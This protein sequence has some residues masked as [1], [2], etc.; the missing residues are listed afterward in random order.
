MIASLLESENAPRGAICVYPK[1]EQSMNVISRTVDIITH[2]RQSAND[3]ITVPLPLKA[4][5]DCLSGIGRTVYS[6]LTLRIIEY[7]LLVLAFHH[8]PKTAAYGFIAGIVFSDEVNNT[9]KNVKSIVKR[10]PWYASIFCA[11]IGGAS[12]YS[13][14]TVSISTIGFCLASNRGLRLI[15]IFPPKD[16]SKNHI[17]KIQDIVAHLYQ[18]ANNNIAVPLKDSSNNPFAEGKITC[19]LSLKNIVA[20]AINIVVVA[21]NIVVVASEALIEFGLTIVTF[22]FLPEISF[23]GFAAA[24]VFPEKIRETVN[25]INA[26]YT[27]LKNE[28]IYMHIL[29]LPFH[30][31]FV[32]ASIIA[33]PVCVPV[34]AFY[35]GSKLVL[36]I[37]EYLV[38][39]KKSELI[40]VRKVDLEQWLQKGQNSHRRASTVDIN[41]LDGKH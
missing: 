17:T 1:K 19:D 33:I 20:V 25:K 13:F 5:Y 2:P 16:N 30:A 40:T 11:I 28:P 32:A 29:Y 12:I 18:S 3:F 27:G 34:T 15:E 36:R 6:S 41:L 38:P 39:P 23:C 26:I 9:I 7:F 37:V 8:A 24:L 35:Y 21:I 31:P 14:K 4:S 22:Y 10:Q